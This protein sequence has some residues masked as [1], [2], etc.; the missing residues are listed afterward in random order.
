MPFFQDKR[1]YYRCCDCQLVFVPAHQRLNPLE[2]KAVYDKH[3]NS[4]D[5]VNYR[6]FL[7]RIFLPI[8]K[9]IA[10]HSHGLDFGCGPGPTL[11][12]MF[13]EA[14]HT[15]NIYDPIYAPDSQCFEQQY[16]FISSSEVMEHCY[17]PGEELSQ[18]WSCLKPDGL[19]GI[20]T[21]RVIDKNAFVHW[22]YKNDPT[23][24]CFFSVET[25]QWLAR[26]W[27]ATLIIA[28][29]DVVIFKKT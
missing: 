26:L 1:D 15:M 17:R 16:D 5:D 4:P 24:V 29:K 21:K 7:Q 2:E 14:G 11:S 3:E 25:F 22:H 13:I 28:D 10:A 8:A 19:L 9:N 6:R 20:M 23:H 12:I 27:Q 18:L